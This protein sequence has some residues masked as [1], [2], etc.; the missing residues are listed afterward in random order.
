MVIVIKPVFA[1]I[2]DVEIFPSVV[3]VVSRAN[4]L[5]PARSD[6]S[7]LLSHVGESSIMIVVIQMI[8]RSLIGGEALQRCAIHDEDVGPS[9][10]VIIENGDAGS[11]RLDDV[12]LGVHSAENICH[13]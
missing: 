8:R 1:I 5:A 10:V 6:E 12:F 4:S 7:R 9:V 2:G 11:S 13:R 3:V